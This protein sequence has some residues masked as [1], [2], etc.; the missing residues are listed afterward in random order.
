[1]LSVLRVP[2]A[3]AAVS[4]LAAAGESGGGCRHGGAPPSPSAATSAAPSAAAP[5]ERVLGTE[6]DGKT[7]ELAQGDTLT[8]RLAGHAGTG[9]AWVLAAVDG[10]DGGVLSQ[11]GERTS[12]LASDTPGAPKLDVY[13]FVARS[14]GTRTVEMDL[15]RPWGDQPA[16]KTWRVTV[17]VR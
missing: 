3:L 8:V 16:V 12:E 5:A 14:A 1:V 10:G 11:V 2:L 4:L 15:R 13:R 9:F 17:N 6:D 7:L